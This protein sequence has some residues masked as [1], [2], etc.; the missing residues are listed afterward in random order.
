MLCYLFTEVTADVKSKHFVL[1]FK[2]MQNNCI[3]V[4]IRM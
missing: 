1:T 4:T 3:M 2:I